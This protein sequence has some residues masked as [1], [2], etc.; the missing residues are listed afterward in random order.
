M[1]ELFLISY[2]SA[3]TA[4]SL[5]AKLAGRYAANSTVPD[6]QLYLGIEFGAIN[7]F[8]SK[9]GSIDEHPMRDS[10]MCVM[11]CMNLNPQSRGNIT[12]TTSDPLAPPR[13][14]ANDLDV[15]ADVLRMVDCAQRLVGISKTNAFRSANATVLSTFPPGSPCSP[16]LPGT[17]E[18]WVCLIRSY[19]TQQSHPVG[20]CKMGPR[21][22]PL[23]VVDHTMKV[24]RVGGLRVVDGSVMP[25]IVSGNP[26]ATIIMIAEKIADEVKRQWSST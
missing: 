23:A 3:S 22:D 25:T 16:L 17:D 11:L 7:D 20:T 15:D 26:E 8:C 24:H 10:R 6:L 14:Y 18:F 5:S 12:L 21:S 2:V 1:E 19:A 13:I 4:T 9:T